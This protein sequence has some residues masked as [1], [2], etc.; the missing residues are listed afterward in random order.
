MEKKKEKKEE[1]EV[2]ILDVSGS[3][4]LIDYN[5]IGG[6]FGL[7]PKSKIHAWSDIKSPCAD[8]I[9]LKT[10]F[11]ETWI[12]GCTKISLMIDIL[13]DLLKESQYEIRVHTDGFN[14][15]SSKEQ[16]KNS[17]LDLYSVATKCKTNHVKIVPTAGADIDLLILVGVILCISNPLISV[18]FPGKIPFDRLPEK[19]DL[20]HSE[21]FI[22]ISNILNKLP[23]YYLTCSDFLHASK[24]DSQSTYEVFLSCQRP[25]ISVLITFLKARFPNGIEKDTLQYFLEINKEFFHLSTDYVQILNYFSFMTPEGKEAKTMS[26][27]CI[28][29]IL[30]EKKDFLLYDS[31]QKEIVDILEYLY[32]RLGISDLYLYLLKYRIDKSIMEH[33]CFT[34]DLMNNFKSP[35]EPDY[36]YYSDANSPIG[37]RQLVNPQSISNL[38]SVIVHYYHS[39]KAEIE[40]KNIIDASINFITKFLSEMIS[41]EPKLA[42]EYSPNP[43][44]LQRVLS[45]HCRYILEQSV[46][47]SLADVEEFLTSSKESKDSKDSLESKEGKAALFNHCV[48]EMLFPGQ[49]FTEKVQHFVDGIRAIPNKGNNKGFKTTKPYKL[50]N[51]VF[52]ILGDLVLNPHHYISNL[53][54]NFEC[55]RE[56]HAPKL[57]PS[58]LVALA[59]PPLNDPINIGSFYTMFDVNPKM[60]ENL[61]NK[62]W[63]LKEHLNGRPD[64]KDISPLL[65][66][67]VFP[68]DTTLIN[69]FLEYF[70]DTLQMTTSRVQQHLIIKRVDTHNFGSF[71]Y[72]NHDIPLLGRRPSGRYNRSGR[73][74]EERRSFLD[75]EKHDQRDH[76]NYVLHNGNLV[77]FVVYLMDKYTNGPI[78]KDSVFSSTE[79]EEFKVP[80]LDILPANMRYL[81]IINYNGLN[82]FQILYLEYAI[83]NTKKHISKFLCNCLGISSMEDYRNLS[84]Y[85]KIVIED[86]TRSSINGI[87][88]TMFENIETIL[89]NIFT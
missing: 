17:L 54:Y 74:N 86:L 8:F 73:N 2:L 58:N 88:Y 44:D 80:A 6:L 64:S 51:F 67:F 40:K 27:G 1:E 24:F 37:S 10:S 53:K 48:L 59:L 56:T 22:Y 63:K 42:L 5:I 70:R 47:F 57:Y 83:D 39:D 76:K 75:F 87:V 13:S 84:E 65:S 36:Y 11:P 23:T 43:S 28:P 68:S 25:G 35:I 31:L 78:C 18:D 41:N 50:S 19:L 61:E 45:K 33:L 85:D 4:G 89:V 49:S 30:M 15:V 71:V 55:K 46:D 29:L 62:V 14:N 66:A 60:K 77:Y 20:S 21:L 81:S 9:D 72:T 79:S 69:K 38:M 52:D 3:M 32:S 12:R 26:R 82:V 7:Q 16:I 34:I